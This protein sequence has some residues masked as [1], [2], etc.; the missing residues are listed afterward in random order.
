MAG[1]KPQARTGLAALLLRGVVGNP[2]ATI[3][4]LMMTVTAAAIMTN[5]LALQP[6]RHPAPLFVGTRPGA[7]AD[8]A[9][10]ATMPVLRSSD[11]SIVGAVDNS[12]I[13]D[14][15]QGLKDFGYYKGDVD[16][17]AGPQTSQAILAFER[18]FHITPT[19]VPSNN[20]L[21]AIRSVRP[22]TSLNG[23]V[24]VEADPLTVASLPASNG[25]P[26]PR[27]KPNG[28]ETQSALPGQTAPAAVVEAARPA[29]SPLDGI[30]DLIANVA[31]SA[32]PA[33]VAPAPVA[34][35]PVVTAAPPVTAAAAP[36]AP[37]G[38]ANLAR[39][40]RSLA[41]QGFGPLAADGKM[42]PETRAAIRQ[43]EDYYG[44]PQT[45][46]INEAFLAQLVKVGGL[47]AN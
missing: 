14:I 33:K 35:A 25:V 37:V 6:G 31:P 40:Q 17:L 45:G 26:T 8:Q 38:D 36:A 34:V 12:L 4:G 2:M 47:Q 41:E 44:L 30:G 1:R 22:K 20:V 39:I 21:L 3:G 32:R 7:P 19:G 29:A 24:P 9:P 11:G 27:P 10:A 43:F 13:A 46:T 42:S 18:A 28:S 23:A 15:Q 5:A 16:G